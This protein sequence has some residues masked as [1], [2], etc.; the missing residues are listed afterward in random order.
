MNIG[1][2]AL[3]G[4]VNRTVKQMAKIKKDRIIFFKRKH[5]SLIWISIKYFAQSKPNYLVSYLGSYH[6]WSYILAHKK[7]FWNVLDISF[8]NG[9]NDALCLS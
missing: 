7:R 6:Y 9:Q 5:I 1:K 8:Q 3:K 2:K 4:V